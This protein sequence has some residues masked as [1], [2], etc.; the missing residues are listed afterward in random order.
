LFGSTLPFRIELHRGGDLI[1]SATAGRE[2][3]DATGHLQRTQGVVGINQESGAV[4]TP[5]DSRTIVALSHCS[6]GV[7]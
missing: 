1:A 4:K 7:Q 5:P 3:G 6:I 2:F